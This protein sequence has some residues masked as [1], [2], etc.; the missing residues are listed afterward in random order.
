MIIAIFVIFLSVWASFN[1][2]D[3][4]SCMISGVPGGS[5]N[6]YPAPFPIGTWTI[7]AP[8][9]ALHTA[10]APFG[11]SGCNSSLNLLVRVPDSLEANDSESKTVKHLAKA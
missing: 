1:G 11:F 10:P 4:L 6:A 9:M 2:S 5:R 7:N 3:D 8:P